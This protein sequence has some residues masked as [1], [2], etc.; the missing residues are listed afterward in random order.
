Y[1]SRMIPDRSHILTEQS[2]PKSS[3]LD[4]LSIEEAVALMNAED[5]RAAA[6]VAGER[7]A[8]AQGVRLVADAFEVG[9]RLIYIGAG[10]S[11]RLGVLDAAE[12]PPTFCSEPEMVVG[13][14]AGGDTARRRSCE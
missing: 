12:C 14:I 1:T 7:T 4:A 3:Q 6:A 11:G 2:N 13:G 10:T 5:A 9:G 8:I